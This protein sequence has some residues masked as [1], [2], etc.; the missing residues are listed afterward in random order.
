LELLPTALLYSMSS[1][2][3]LGQRLSPHDELLETMLL[4]ISL[5]TSP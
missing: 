5:L 3:P 1:E 4:M 2:P